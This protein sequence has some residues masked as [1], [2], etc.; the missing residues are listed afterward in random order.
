MLSIFYETFYEALCL[1][2]LGGKNTFLWFL[3]VITGIFVID[4][5]R[6]IIAQNV[7]FKSNKST[8]SIRQKANST[9][10]R[11]VL[12]I[13]NTT[14]STRTTEIEAAAATLVFYLPL[15]LKA[16]KFVEIIS[17]LMTLTILVTFILSLRS[18]RIY[19]QIKRAK[20]TIFNR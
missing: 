3:T 7:F 15:L 9:L 12:E 4:S 5:W 13:I 1:D 2:V 19:K 14:T 8:E 16:V 11:E 17:E 18:N 6:G 10:L 20:P